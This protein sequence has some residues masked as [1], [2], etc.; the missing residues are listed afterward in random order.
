[1]RERQVRLL[2]VGRIVANVDEIRAGRSGGQENLAQVP[3]L[4]CRD[5]VAV[6]LSSEYGRRSGKRFGWQQQIFRPLVCVGA[7]DG[8]FSRRRA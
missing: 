7:L 4:R 5:L 1:M 8:S 6:N 2:L 3:A